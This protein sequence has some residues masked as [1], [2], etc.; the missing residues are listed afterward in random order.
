MDTATD[1]AITPERLTGLLAPGRTLTEFWFYRDV[2]PEVSIE[3]PTLYGKELDDDLE[4]GRHRA[5][6]VGERQWPRDRL[7]DA[8]ARLQEES[9][10]PILVDNGCRSVADASLFLEQGAKAIPMNVDLAQASKY[11]VNPLSGRQVQFGNLF[12]THPPLEDRI[13]RLRAGEWRG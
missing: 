11:I 2:A 12:R 1:R 9:P 8:F 3:V 6:V 7:W 10:I 4:P 5:P 13:A